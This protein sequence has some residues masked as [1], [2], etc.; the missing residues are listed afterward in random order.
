M[1]KCK[2]MNCGGFYNK[3]SDWFWISSNKVQRSCSEE[4]YNEH[5]EKTREARRRKEKARARNGKPKLTK[6]QANTNR[7][8]NLPMR[9]R[10]HIMERDHRQCVI[11]TGPGTQVHHVVFRSQGGQ[12]EMSN[13]VFLCNRCHS[14]RAHGVESRTFRQLFLAYIWIRYTQDRV[15]E[16][17]EVLVATLEPLASELSE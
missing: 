7:K 13:L 4:C 10:F 5:S 3:D 15:P 11:C 16:W 8:K 2:C 17:G 9:L 14:E 12:H 6:R 1:A